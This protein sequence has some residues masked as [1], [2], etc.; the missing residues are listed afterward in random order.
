MALAFL[1]TSCNGRLAI[2]SQLLEVIS[3]GG[4]DPRSLY[5]TLVGMLRQ[6]F[7]RRCY[8]EVATE[9]L[10]AGSFRLTRVWLENGGEG[11]PNNSPWQTAGVP[12][13]SGGIVAEVLAQEKAVAVNR[14]T[15]PPGDPV[16]G[17]LGC[18]KSL[19]ATPGG[20]G[21]RRNW[22][23]IFEKA[24]D[25]FTEDDVAYLMLRVNL[26]GLSLKNIYLLRDLQRATAYVDAEVDRM[27]EIQKAL[28][29][30]PNPIVPGLE[31]AAMWATFDRA[32]GDAYDYA[33]LPNGRWGFLI[34]DASGHGPSAAV[35]SAIINAVMHTLPFVR[36]VGEP[37]PAT[38]LRYANVQLAG[39]RIGHSF[40]TAFVCSWDPNQRSL[41]YARAGHNPPILVRRGAATL[42]DAVGDIP[43]G[44]LDDVDY[45]EATLP[46]EPEDVILLFT[47]GI[48]ESVDAAGE[49][50][51]LER[52]IEALMAST[53][54]ATEM[55][56]QVT[57][58]VHNHQCGSRSRDDQ[59][60]LLMKVLP[61]GLGNHL[62]PSTA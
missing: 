59:T 57:A 49:M 14:L 37:G 39:K 56:S 35:V 53:G 4:K 38:V 44:I 29:P 9:G 34:S 15:I 32:G 7:S 27:A 45:H 11:V 48:V 51:G 55:L 19:V 21:D 24:Q 42:L 23:F 31:V 36:P 22:V 1:E 2:F 58:K 46:L 61:D 5:V 28:L 10:P 41:R 47:D 25:A 52:L 12:I 3:S 26:I 16:Y 33:E 17:E 13:R 50:F 62:P 30:P 6:A 8:V 18:Y 40:V 43:L 60:M 54:S 20:I